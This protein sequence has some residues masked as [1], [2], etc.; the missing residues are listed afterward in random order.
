[1]KRTVPAALSALALAGCVALT[2][3]GASSGEW[4]R[5]VVADRAA[6]AGPARGFNSA[7]VMFLQMMVPH[8]GQ[9]VELARL[10]GGRAA[11]QE[12]RILAAA[13][14]TAQEAETATM[15][16]WLRD[17]DQPATA[18]ADEHASHGGMPETSEREVAEVAGAAPADFERRFLDALIAHQDDAVQLARAEA[19]AGLHPEVR[20]LAERIDASRT[21]Q[22]GHML[23]LRGR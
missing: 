5:G 8:N 15:A 18:P 23:R 2:G 21:A 20:R 11:R 10:A 14:V 6:E 22:I 1:M 16:G 19:V 13:I 9:G 4:A 12:V 7:D 17:W 3:C